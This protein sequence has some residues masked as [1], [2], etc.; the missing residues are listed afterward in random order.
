M[1]P[2]AE[3]AAVAAPAAR[4]ARGGKNGKPGAAP[5]PP[6]RRVNLLTGEDLNTRAERAIALAYRGQEG[7]SLAEFLMIIKTNP[8]FEF[9][10]L[11]GFYD[12]PAAGYMA[13]AR[14]YAEHDRRRYATALLKLALESYP[15]DRPLA[16]MLAEVDDAGPDVILPGTASEATS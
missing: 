12:M 2:V 6:P 13:L 7:S 8:E 9:G 10:A 3:S 15:D 11:P 14:A 16:R 1:A 5:T 4:P